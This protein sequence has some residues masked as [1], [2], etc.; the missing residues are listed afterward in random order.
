[1]AFSYLVIS[2]IHFGSGVNKTE[3]IVKNLGKYFL[4]YHKIISKLD[5]IFIAGDIFD[6]LLTSSS[7]DYID[8]MQWL[9]KLARY[10]M[11]NDIML[12]I[13]EGTPSHDSKQASVFDI[14][15]SELDINV[16][17]KYVSELYIEHI[18]KHNID[19]LYVPDEVN[20]TS[21]ETFEQVKELLN[22]HNLNKVDIAIMHGAFSYQ[23]PAIE[24]PSMH[25]ERDYLNIVKSYIS[26]GHVHTYSTYDRILAQGSFDRL[27]HNEE[28]SKGGIV[29]TLDN[30]KGNSYKI[31][32]NNHATIFKTIDITDTDLNFMEEL[33]N[34]ILKYPKG[35]NIRLRTTEDNPIN[36]SILEIRKRYP[37]HNITD[38]RNKNSKQSNM[39]TNVLADVKFTNIQ[40][41]KDNIVKL[42]SD[43][44]TDINVDIK[45]IL[46]DE[47]EKIRV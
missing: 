17:F 25:N 47:L 42:V 30:D 20:S 31:L 6:R 3:N 2:D 44:L 16:D 35:S 46:F 11:S 4:E 13:L 15:L 1:M 28:G 37:Y 45:N 5:V 41:T 18:D 39:T 36:K 7:Q 38:T 29:I 40:I 8:S 24:L 9:T 33:D 12:R 19:V 27:A 22:A 26:V 34:L 14:V 21:K 23:I 32:K 43:E 10:C